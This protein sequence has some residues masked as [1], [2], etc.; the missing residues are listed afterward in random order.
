M[1]GPHEGRELALMLAGRKPLAMFTEVL[2]A[3]S[4]LI[5]EDHFLPHVRAGRIVM[6]E[7]FAPALPVAG[8]PG[9]LRLRYV[10]YALPEEAWRID[11]M[12]LLNK[13]YTRQGGWDEGLERL[14]G[15]LLGYS[16]AD[17]EAFVKQIA[18]RRNRK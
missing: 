10:L 5:P 16:E 17:I 14:I 1:I 18:R 11:A 15:C 12:L 8:H 13:V 2:P 9:K 4:G 6:R 3:E 7:A